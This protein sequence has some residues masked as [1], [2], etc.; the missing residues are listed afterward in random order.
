MFSH[1]L[2]MRALP[3]LNE[4]SPLLEVMPET[5]SAISLQEILAYGVEDR[6]RFQRADERQF[7]NGRTPALDTA[8]GW[9][10]VMILR[11]DPFVR[12]VVGIEEVGHFA[13]M[14]GKE[15]AV[16]FDHDGKSARQTANG[17]VVRPMRQMT[18]APL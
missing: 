15:C 18:Q 8:F 9:D 4:P 17:H 7:D 2:P 11:G 13:L 6:F 12:L 5:E 14:A 3:A 1:V 16:R 10:S